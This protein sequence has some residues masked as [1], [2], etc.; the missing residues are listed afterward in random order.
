MKILKSIFAALLLAS[1]IISPQ[2]QNN[3]AQESDNKINASAVWNPSTEIMQNIISK[4]AGL[5]DNDIYD[6][7]INEME[8][9]GASPQAVKFAELLDGP[10]Y[11]K[12]FKS[13]G[14]VD[15]AYV[16]YMFKSTGH[17]G[18]FII[19]GSPNLIDIDDYNLLPIA[20]LES[21][22]QYKE[23]Q[24]LYP[25]ISI[26]SGDR[27]STDYPQKEDLPHKEERVVVNYNLRNGCGDCQNLGY[28]DFGFDFDSTGKFINAKFIDVKK[29]PDLNTALS[30]N[31][32]LQNVFNDPSKPIAVSS[33]E[34]FSIVLISNHSQG[35]QWELAEPL[36]NKL[37]NLLG[38]DY[39]KPFET[40]PN[41]AGKEAWSFKAIGTGSTEIKFRY[42]YSWKADSEPMQQFTFLVNIQ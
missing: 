42:V 18:C 23:L 33:G 11:M 38:T 29:A 22:Q 26:F 1:S 19:N 36:D 15:I 12:T 7:F 3:T 16:H 24:K 10:G 41:A 2:T 40:L 27:L 37:I 28:A 32:N 31:G 4:C 13:L 6:C 34:E 35:L 17:E 25:Q 30:N 14:S 39:T 9:A 8:S 21:T 5:Q 20:Y